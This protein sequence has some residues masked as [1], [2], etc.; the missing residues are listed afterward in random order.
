MDALSGEEFLRLSAQAKSEDVS[1]YL[2]E[3]CLDC[4][5]LGVT[6]VSILLDN[7]PTHKQKMR[8]Q[9]TEHLKQM[10]LALEIE[11][12]FI[13]LP[14][15]SPKLN[16]VEYVIHLLR[17][18]FLHHLPL[19]TCLEYIEQKLEDFLRSHQ[20]LSTEQVQKTLNFIFSSV[21]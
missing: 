18:R 2:A 9:L 15:Y 3:L 19:G 4:I 5:E 8:T 17:L 16:L 14:P 10:G 7:N 13:Y 20:F 6:K 1:L 11:V 21:T 12:E